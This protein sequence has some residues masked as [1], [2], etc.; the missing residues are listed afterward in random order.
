MEEN[1]ISAQGTDFSSFD[2]QQEKEK[3][4]Q[5]Y[6]QKMTEAKT[7]DQYEELLYDWMALD[8]KDADQQAEICEQKLKALETKRKKRDIGITIVLIVAMICYFC[9]R[10]LM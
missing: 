3:E 9:V 1:K 2:D 10:R 8:Y 4:Y 6:L 7:Y 5:S